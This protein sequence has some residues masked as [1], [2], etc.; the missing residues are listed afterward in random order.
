MKHLIKKLSGLLDKEI[1]ITI[2]T[3]KP[4]TQHYVKQSSGYVNPFKHQQELIQKR[5]QELAQKQQQELERKREEAL[6]Q[7]K[8]KELEQ[9]HQQEL[10][11]KQLLEIKRKHEQQ[12]ELQH[13]KERER[14]QAKKAEA[15][16]A[17]AKQQTVQLPKPEPTPA[18]I[19]PAPQIK[20]VESVAPFDPTK[21]AYKED[22]KV[23]KHFKIKKPHLKMPALPLG[24]YPRHIAIVVVLI[25]G[26]TLIGGTIIKMQQPKKDVKAITTKNNQQ[27]TIPVDP[28]SKVIEAVNKRITLP[29]NE[30]PVLATVEDVEKLRD[31]DFFKEARNGDKI[32]MYRSNKKAYLYRPETDEVLVQAP[33][34]YQDQQE[35]IASGSGKPAPGGNP[36]AEPKHGKTLVEP[37]E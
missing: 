7:Q 15:A 3:K 32:L 2:P 6:R 14:E 19:K 11:E 36:Q 21:L 29:T 25:V 28:K 20:A 27:E 22:A 26:T 13:L 8:L 1:E 37:E 4:K 24:K 10:R 23:K 12:Q 31:Q 16:A 5:Q 34:I 9:K 35:L 18:P 30:V 17:H 33:L